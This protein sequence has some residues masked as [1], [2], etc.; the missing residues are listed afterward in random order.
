MP[1]KPNEFIVDGSLGRFVSCIVQAKFFFLTHIDDLFI[2][3][4][5]LLFEKQETKWKRISTICNGTKHL[6]Q[7]VDNVIK[8][9]NQSSVVQPNHEFHFQKDLSVKSGEKAVA[10]E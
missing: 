10:S 6:K 1:C 8:M 3:F 7:W 5:V 9:L 4:E 2:K